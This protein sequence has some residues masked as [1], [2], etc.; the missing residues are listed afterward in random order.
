MARIVGVNLPPNKRIEIG[1]TYIFGIGKTRA[2]K[3]LKE[4]KIDKN[5]KVKDLTSEEIENIRKII[6]S[7]YRTEGTLKRDIKAN[8]KRLKEINS[9]RGL[10]HS[11]NL[12]VHGQRTKTNSRT[13]RGNV[14]RPV[15]GAKKKSVAKT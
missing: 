6:D 12:P 15:G 14:R 5:K 7:Q 11:K 8:I 1:L 3:I 10:R 13:R 2:N 4:T 9:Y